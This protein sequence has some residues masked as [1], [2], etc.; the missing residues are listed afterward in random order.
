MKQSKATIKVKLI[1]LLSFLLAVAIGNA[2]F[3]FVLDSH[4]EKKLEWVIHTN[5]VIIKTETYLSSMQD[6]ETGQRGYLLTND[7]SYLEPYHKGIEQAESVLGK[8]Q[9]LVADNPE[10]IQR[11]A[12]IKVSMQKKLDEL[13]TTIQLTQDGKPNEALALVKKNIGKR[14]MDNIRL[15]IREFTNAELILLEKR[16]GEYRAHKAQITTLIAVEI[17][18]FLFLAVFSITF[19]D[20]LLFTPLHTLLRSTRRMEEG[21]KLDAKDLTSKDEM[22]YLLYSFFKMNEKVHKRTETLDRKAH[23]DELTGLLNRTNVLNEVNNAIVHAIESGKKT[24]ILFLDLNKFKTINDTLG[25]DVG[26]II[27]QNA[28]KRLT[29]S[30]RADDLVFRIGGDEFAI[31][32]TG[33]AQKD[34]VQYI[35]EKILKSFENPMM[36]QGKQLEVSTSIGAAIAPDSTENAEELLKMADVAMYDSKHNQESHFAFFEPDMLKRSN[37]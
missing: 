7:N 33:I 32:L 36:I 25:H 29:E 18:F 10:Q 37:D 26:D 23:H 31:L 6:T 1:V 2:A 19:L 13:A 11:L 8:L 24:A 3:T 4:G 28:A 5:D 9:M 22:G 30:T 34:D 14:H 35:V 12:L 17:V 21:K 16:K 20:R 15:L 27:L